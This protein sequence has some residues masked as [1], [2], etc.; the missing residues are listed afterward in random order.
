MKA[1][2]L[3]DLESASTL[4][5][6]GANVCLSGSAKESPISI[7]FGRNI[8]TLKKVVKEY[9]SAKKY[10]EFEIKYQSANKAFLKP[11]SS[12]LDNR[13]Q[14]SFLGSIQEPA[15][16]KTN[17]NFSKQQ[18][19][20]KCIDKPLTEKTEVEDAKQIVS[21]LKK[22]TTSEEVLTNNT[23]Q[24]KVNIV[25]PHEKAFGGTELELNN[26]MVGKLSPKHSLP[27][28]RQKIA[29]YSEQIED[30]KTKIE[31]IKQAS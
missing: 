8:L 14:N 16:P 24:E 21:H 4:I 29:M 26:Q 23:N 1:L 12:R 18:E 3:N 13:S 7:I 30:V 15:I 27:V 2:R 17:G 28:Y 5:K 11:S 10:K 22:R 25:T 31:A 20:S 6:L 9:F 19:P